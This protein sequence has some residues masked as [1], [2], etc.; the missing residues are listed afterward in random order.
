LYLGNIQCYVLQE[1][2]TTTIRNS[3]FGRSEAE[4]RRHLWQGAGGQESRGSR[5]CRGSGGRILSQ[6]LPLL[7]PIP[8][9]PIPDREATPDSLLA[10]FFY[11]FNNLFAQTSIVEAIDFSNTCRAGNVNFS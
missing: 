10:S 3:S 4:G 7:P 11:P 2:S 9:L 1:D 5:G 8:R 6:F